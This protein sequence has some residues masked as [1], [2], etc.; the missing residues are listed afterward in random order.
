MSAA[1]SSAPDSCYVLLGIQPQPRF[2]PY[3]QTRPPSAH[4]AAVRQTIQNYPPTEPDKRAA[5]LGLKSWTHP[6]HSNI[7]KS[8]L[9]WHKGTTNCI[10]LYNPVL[11]N[12]RYINLETVDWLWSKPPNF[13]CIQNSVQTET[14]QLLNSVNRSSKDL[15]SPEKNKLTDFQFGTDAHEAQRMKPWWSW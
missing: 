11:W 14:P 12:D 15:H 3:L 8:F 1:Q 6:Q 7:K 5:S 4:P 13:N 10:L 2:L 9:V